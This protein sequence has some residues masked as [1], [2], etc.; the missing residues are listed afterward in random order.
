MKRLRERA[1]N[2]QARREASRAHPHSPQKEWTCSY[3]DFQLLASRTLRKSVNCWLSPPVYGAL[4]REPRRI[5]TT[6]LEI[7]LCEM[8]HFGV[9]NQNFEIAELET[10]QS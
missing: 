10:R 7:F 5:N 2:Y 9:E 4:L 8:K 1:A 3:L 6:T